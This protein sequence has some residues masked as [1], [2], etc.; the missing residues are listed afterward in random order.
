[1]LKSVFLLIL[2]KTELGAI[3]ITYADKDYLIQAGIFIRDMMKMGLEE[4]NKDVHDNR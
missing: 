1:M 4:R 3:I 2:S